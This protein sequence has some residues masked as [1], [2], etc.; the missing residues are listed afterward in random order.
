MAN[1]K[2]NPTVKDLVDLPFMVV[3]ETGYEVESY[4]T[5]QQ[6]IK[7]IEDRY[8]E[9][10]DEFEEGEKYYILEQVKVAEITVPPLKKLEIK[11][12]K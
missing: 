2:T 6:A 3:D 11:V 9:Y 8:N 5:L 4:E 12:V 1:K 7:E 10:P